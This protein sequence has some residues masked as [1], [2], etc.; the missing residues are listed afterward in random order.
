MCIRDR[1][2]YAGWLTKDEDFRYTAQE[3]EDIEPGDIIALLTDRAM[4]IYDGK[5]QQYG[6]QLMREL[7]RVVLLKTV[8]MCIRDRNTTYG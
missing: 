6:D 3:Q 4:E 8:E 1:D 2:Y 5:E 7:E